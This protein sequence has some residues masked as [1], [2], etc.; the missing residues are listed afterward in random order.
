MPQQKFIL[1]EKYLHFVDNTI[2]TPEHGRR[3]KIVPIFD[4]LADTFR[5]NY[6]PERNV[7]GDKRKPSERKVQYEKYFGVMCLGW[8]DKL[9]V[10]MMSTCMADNIS[11][12]TRK[13]KVEQVPEIIET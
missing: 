7:V 9:D 12:V 4:Y 2:L 1:T 5:C 13:G 6:I 8:K 3:A 11:N 10:Y